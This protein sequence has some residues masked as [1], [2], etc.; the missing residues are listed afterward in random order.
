ML[1]NRANLLRLKGSKENKL[2]CLCLARS[3]G[4]K[5][6]VEVLWGKEKK[7]LR[8]RKSNK[9]WLVLFLPRTPLNMLC[10][11]ISPSRDFCIHI[12]L[13]LFAYALQYLQRHPTSMIPCLQPAH[14]E[15][16]ASS[17]EMKCYSGTS[18]ETLGKNSNEWFE[19]VIKLLSF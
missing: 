13:T 4:E 1:L 14:G 11:V 5:F 8:A 9:V 7:V 2:Q 18:E 19:N 10:S 3:A 6:K 16:Y 15:I 17:G 12:L